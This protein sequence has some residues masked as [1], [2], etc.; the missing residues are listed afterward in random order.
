MLAVF[1]QVIH[2]II[3]FRRIILKPSE[4]G[5][6]SPLEFSI[7]NTFSALFRNDDRSS[8]E[9]LHFSKD[10]SDELFV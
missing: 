9:F 2:F 5:N 7:G 8:Q 4:G 10:I 3:Q 6:Y 1:P